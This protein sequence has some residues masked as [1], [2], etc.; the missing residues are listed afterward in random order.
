M[1]ISSLIQLAY[2]CSPTIDVCW[3]NPS[4]WFSYIMS[5]FDCSAWI[6]IEVFEVISNNLRENLKRGGSENINGCKLA[7]V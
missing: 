6:L 1:H 5:A 4:V 3:Y 2:C 7:H